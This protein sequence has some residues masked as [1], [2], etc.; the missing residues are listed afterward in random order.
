MAG[1]A[2]A[3]ASPR[4]DFYQSFILPEITMRFRVFIAAF[5]IAGTIV[6]TAS[7]TD[8]EKSAMLELISV[9]RIW[10]AAP[11]NAFTDLTK[12]KDRWY[13]T[14]RE[15][16]LHIS[17]DGK[18]RVIVSDDCEQWKSAALIAHP[19]GELRDP[20]FAVTPDNR[21]MLIGAVRYGE[22]L[23]KSTF[24]TLVWFSD[25]GHTW[26]DAQEIGEP[27]NW[28]WS[29]TWQG[30]T[31]Y[32][33]GYG[34][35]AVA[36]THLFKSS[37]GRKWQS[38]VRDL[39]PE[40]SGGNESSL[41]FASDKTAYCLIRRDEGTKSGQ[42]GIA[43]PPYTDWK[44]LDQGVRI[45]GPKMIQLPDGRLLAAVRLYDGTM[46]TS[47]C[48]IDAKTGKLTEAVPLPSGGGDTSY[49]GMVLD[50]NVVRTSYY[51]GHEGKVSIYLANAK[52][53]SGTP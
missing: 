40:R 31:A 4:N 12:F 34:C 14:F 16:E 26:S 13:C 33:V 7:A 44:W 27:N 22:P 21:L 1:E 53:V 30:D 19:T 9:N 35:G 6:S 50:G 2:V 32:G 11:H 51:S 15:G 41:V 17:S 25:D 38:V 24:Q 3:L 42:L 36:D 37:D 10:D 20:K 48:W 29:V 18:L 28:I 5:I 49:A 46:R 45:G 23:E 8:D 39:N 47:L 43:R 52:V